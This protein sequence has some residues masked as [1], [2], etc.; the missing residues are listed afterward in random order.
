M[1]KQQNNNNTYNAENI[2][3]LKGLEAVRK[4]PAMYVGSTG[5]VGLHHLV[6]E[7]VDNSV[8]ESLAGFCDNIIV[9]LNRDGSITIEDNG[10]G[11]PVDIH[12]IYKVPA[13]EVALTKLHAGGKFDKK[14]YL[15][16][17]GLHG[18]GLS[19]VNALSSKLRVNIKRDNK[20]YGQTYSRGKVLSKLEVEK[21]IPEGE[22][23][24]MITFIPDEEIF[25]EIK[26]DS[27]ILK[28][29]LREIAFLNAGLKISFIDNLK[30]K[31]DKFFYPGGLK[32]F[33]EWLD[34]GKTVL[35]KPTYFKKQSEKIVAEICFQYTNSYRES[36]FGF[37][38]TISTSEGGMHISGFKSALTRVVDRKSTRLNSSHTDISRMPSSA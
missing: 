37:V 35:H 18:I 21:E 7:A 30:G 4:R 29:R 16:S 32:E 25:S 15:I 1:D 22:T 12:P 5:K 34:R 14:T 33:V 20:L 31:K 6:Y 2:N 28:T 19:C 26:F 38:N 17:G 3:V 23:G 13:V 8:D 9:T 10:R 24:T 11:I 36:I 27:E